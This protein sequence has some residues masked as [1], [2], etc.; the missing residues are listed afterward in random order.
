MYYVYDEKYRERIAVNKC[1]V[2]E[3]YSFLQFSSL[4]ILLIAILLIG[5][6]LHSILSQTGTR[7]LEFKQLKRR[8]IRQSII[9]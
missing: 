8:K 2:Y 1:Q 4:Y 5:V 9:A 3:P 7:W 6:G